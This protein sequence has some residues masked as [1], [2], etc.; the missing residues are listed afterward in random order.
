MGKQHID[1][2]VC[3]M[4]HHPSIESYVD[5]KMMAI[6]IEIFVPE[7]L[8]NT[9]WAQSQKK[10]EGQVIEINGSRLAGAA[11]EEAMRANMD[12]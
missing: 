7:Y 8:G 12:K 4:V 11:A 1:F 5:W 2:L 10:I 3:S 6:I 9:D